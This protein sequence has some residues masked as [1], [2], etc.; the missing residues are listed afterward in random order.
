MWPTQVSGTSNT[1][2]LSDTGLRYR[3][4]A[5]VGICALLAGAVIATWLSIQAG[6][7]AT[8]ALYGAGGAAH[9]TLWMWDGTGYEQRPVP[10]SGPSSNEADM[11][12]DRS[13]GVIVLWDHGCSSMV[14]GFQGGCVSHVNRTWTW[15]GSAWT[16]HRTQ[17]S[18]T[19]T[20][21][22]AMV[23]DS[24]LGQVAYVN[25]VGQAWSWTGTD[26]AAL[27]LRGGPTVVYPGAGTGSTALLVGYDEGDD[28]L[29]FATSTAT[30]SW[31]GG[32]WKETAGGI[33]AGET[34][35]DAHLVYDRAHHLLVYVGNRATWTWDGARWQPHSQPAISRGTI[36]YDAAHGSLMLVQQDGPICGHTGCGTSTWAWDSAAWSQVPVEHG[37]VSAQARSGA[38]A[39]PMAFDETR[40]V[41]L[42]FASAA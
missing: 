34:R 14:M 30:W 18:P 28:V 11:A 16:A 27:P 19:A 8:P 6:Q 4:L 5:V 20:G 2:R 35:E 9:S 39:M 26:W 31:D 29:V 1:G 33:A 12:Y 15:D 42:L 3:V 21:Q 7:P 41:M 23:F 32:A 10:A 22:G 36:G 25:G 13:S 37:P 17:S 38:F 40:G 24:R